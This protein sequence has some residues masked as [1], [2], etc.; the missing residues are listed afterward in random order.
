[1]RSA[2]VSSIIQKK[3]RPYTSK[4]EKIEE[5]EILLEQDFSTTTINEKWGT[6]ITYIHALREGWC[7]LAS[8]LDL[9]SKKVIGYSF[10]RNMTIDIVVDVLENP[11][12]AQR[13][14]NELILHTDLGSQYTSQG[15]Q[16]LLA[17]L[18]I[19]A[20]FFVSNAVH[21]T[22]LVWNHFMPL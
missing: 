12:S 21:T 5:R 7:Y 4:K 20:S 11:Y 9:H 13:L 3:Y 15:F 17:E 18:K 6:D 2:G 14:F 8:V 19:R 22:T 10:S 1:M 16:L